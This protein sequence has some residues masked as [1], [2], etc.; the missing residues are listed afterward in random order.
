MSY[1]LCPYCQ[2]ADIQL[3]RGEGLF[4]DKYPDSRGNPGWSLWAVC[5]ECEGEFVIRVENVTFIE[6]T[7]CVEMFTIAGF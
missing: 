3:V 7:R 4:T 1:A 5:L 2:E 6:D